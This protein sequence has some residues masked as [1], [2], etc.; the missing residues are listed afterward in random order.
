MPAERDALREALR[1]IA[2]LRMEIGLDAWV[3]DTRA[4]LGG[5]GAK[6]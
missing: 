1:E 5:E 6:P 2:R 4:F 3:M